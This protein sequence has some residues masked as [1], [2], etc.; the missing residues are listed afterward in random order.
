MQKTEEIND[1]KETKQSEIFEQKIEIRYEEKYLNKL[2]SYK[3]EM[4]FTKEELE[5][6]EKMYLQYLQSS[7]E[8]NEKKLQLLES[9]KN[10][11]LESILEDQNDQEEQKADEFNPFTLIQ[12]DIIELIDFKP[13][14]NEIRKE[15]HEYVINDRIEKLINTF[16]MDKTPLGNV[17]MCYNNIKK[18]FEY[19][20]DNTI[21]YRYLET[22]A[23]KYVVTFDCKMLYVDMNIELKN[24]M[25]KSNSMKKDIKEEKSTKTKDLFKD[26]SNK[27]QNQNQNRMNPNI[28]NGKTNTN[29]FMN[30]NINNNNKNNK[31][32]DK[33]ILKENANRYTHNGKYSNINLLKKIDRKIVDKNYSLSYKDFKKINF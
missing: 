13:D 28:R 1:K 15:A 25:N 30:T 21:P 23:R 26:Y 27:N 11:F 31:A 18:S 5:L 9:E 16:I 20:S 8:E 4:T 2:N 33:C 17:M 24:A 6:E 19:Y 14:E 10:A 22:V 32:N 12:N 29:T 3:D 7:M